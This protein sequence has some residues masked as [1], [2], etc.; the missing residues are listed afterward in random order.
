MSTRPAIP[1]PPSSNPWGIYL[2]RD[3]AATGPIAEDEV[4]ELIR[5]GELNPASLVWRPG[6]ADWSPASDVPGLFAPPPSPGSR[7]Q[8]RPIGL[9]AEIDQSTQATRS[10][11][12]SV[13]G[14][15]HRSYIGRH[16]RGELTLERSFLLNTLGLNLILA[17][18]VGAIRETLSANAWGIGHPRS[19]AVVALCASCVLAAVAVWQVIGSW[20]CVAR[21]ERAGERALFRFI[22]QAF[23]VIA[24]LLTFGRFYVEGGP[25]LKEQLRIVTGDPHWPAH[26]VSLLE[27][28]STLKIEGPLRTGIADEVAEVLR[29]H[30]AVTSVSIESPGGRTSESSRLFELFSRRSLHLHASGTCDSACAIAF[31]GG[32]L[33]T[34][35]P[36]SR[37]GF[38]A[39]GYPV[40]GGAAFYRA[41]ADD[42]RDTREL[43]TRARVGD[44]L[45]ER[46][47][48]TPN[49]RLLRPSLSELVSAGYLHRVGNERTDPSDGESQGDQV[50][51]ANRSDVGGRTQTHPPRKGDSQSDFLVKFGV[52]ILLDGRFAKNFG[53][54]PD[55]EM[56]ELLNALLMLRRELRRGSVE[57]CARPWSK[58]SIE[59]IGSIMSPATQEAV[60][61]ALVR[62]YFASTRVAQPFAP[63]RD[64]DALVEATMERVE[65]RVPAA[66][67]ISEDPDSPNASAHDL[68][69][70]EI[71]ILEET[72][73][74]PKS[75]A[76]SVWR[77]I[78]TLE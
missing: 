15:Q 76:A 3:G 40:E 8:S 58:S 72:L 30:P 14:L 41:K 2:H 56:I 50:A 9:I 18:A 67:R 25:F 24:V 31:A 78:Q 51:T 44:A 7:P 74:L 42:V 63:P 34:A 28:G 60:S 49:E 29:A 59:R 57:A 61:L 53:K 46:I 77:F 4:G 32:T 17:I 70:F 47:I 48:A 19:M 6:M 35:A 16:W 75:K 52:K 12:Q 11:N 13:T 5:S 21:Y 45:I 66:S 37:F 64:I 27:D 22:V 39:S 20:R 23:L 71:A 68:C 26:T 36:S 54:I 38:H 69:A 62:A 10:E 43:L 1:F 65:R 55:D 73:A 33:R